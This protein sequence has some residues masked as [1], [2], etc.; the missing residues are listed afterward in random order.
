[1]ENVSKSFRTGFWYKKVEAVR[2]IS[3]TV[4]KGEIFGF[5]GPNGAG[6]T[7]TIKMLMGLISPSGGSIK[8]MG[9]P[10][11]ETNVKKDIG[12]APEQ[13]SFYDHLSGEE[14]LKYCG[15]LMGMGYSARKKRAAELFGIVGLKNC[16]KLSLRKYSKGMQQRM[17]IAQALVSDPAILILDEPMSGLDPAGR[18][19]IRDLIMQFKKQGKTVFF[20]THILSD[21]EMICDRVAIVVKGSIARVGRIEEFTELDSNETE[22]CISGLN[23]DSFE[24][25][26]TSA[27]GAMMKGTLAY[28]TTMSRNAAVELVRA[29]EG[30]GGCLVSFN[31]KR[32]SL[33]D[34]YLSETQK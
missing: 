13:P 9:K 30:R 5:L 2:G 19:E 10:H 23:Q 27:C 17:G 28:F 8:I 14:M 31:P 24:K 26:G 12:Y 29:A 1:M 15:A 33:E 16:E 20:S 32:R 3:L 7:T 4:E 21:V 22:V 18:R 25:L 6:K 34:I 11:T